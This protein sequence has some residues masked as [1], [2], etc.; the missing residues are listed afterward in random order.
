MPKIAKISASPETLIFWVIYQRI[1]KICR[2]VWLTQ[3]HI[4]P[5]IIVGCPCT[6]IIIAL[7]AVLLLIYSSSDRRRFRNDQKP[8]IDTPFH[9]TSANCLRVFA[10][11]CDPRHIPFK[12]KPRLTYKLI[13][14]E[15]LRWFKLKTQKF[16][17]QQYMNFDLC[18]TVAV[19]YQLWNQANWKLN[20]VWVRLNPYMMGI[21]A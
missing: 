8:F 18:D 5:K 9:N 3:L 21:S 20:M 1:T 10:F 19:F 17:S 16:I 7:K 15:Y 14:T 11:M 12:R 4:S 6:V 13:N 2:K